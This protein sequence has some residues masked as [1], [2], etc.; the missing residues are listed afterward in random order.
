MVLDVIHVRKK[1]KDS[2]GV[3]EY[4][5][6]IIAIIDCTITFFGPTILSSMGKYCVLF[7]QFFL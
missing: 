5:V 3:V 1:S 6:D 2:E 7:S 4:I